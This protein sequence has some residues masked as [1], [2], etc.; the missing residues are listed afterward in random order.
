MSTRFP[1]QF[2]FNLYSGWTLGGQETVRYHKTVSQAEK[3]AYTWDRYYV[4]H[5]ETATDQNDCGGVHTNS[6]LL[7]LIS[8][9]LHEKGMPVEDEFYYWMNVMMAIV[10]GIDYPLMA[11]LLP[12]SMKQ[13]GY[14]EWL[15]VLEAAIQET[16]IAETEVEDIPEGCIAVWYELPE[17]LQEYAD[18]FTLSFLDQDWNVVDYTWPDARLKCFLYIMQAGNYVVTLQ[19][20]GDDSESF[21]WVM[22]GDHWIRMDGETPIPDDIVYTYEADYAYELPTEGVE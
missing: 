19:V 10:P 22:A 18:M 6:S 7:N 3:E 2:R 17:S 5:V 8:W 9:R 12:W 1:D 21:S 11:K 4:P 15:P 20:P 13:L 16:R 14:D